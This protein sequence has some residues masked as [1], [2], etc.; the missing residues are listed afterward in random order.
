MMGNLGLAFKTSKLRK[1]VFESRKKKNTRAATLSHLWSRYRLS[2]CETLVGRMGKPTPR[3][4]FKKAAGRNEKTRH[5]YTELYAKARRKGKKNNKI[6]VF[7]FFL[8][9]LLCRRA[10]HFTARFAFIL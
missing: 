5:A 4:R 10:G 3:R 7:F 8:L 6:V 9:L 1:D 2:A